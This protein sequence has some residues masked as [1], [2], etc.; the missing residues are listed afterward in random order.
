[1]KKLQIGID[2]GTTNSVVAYLENGSIEYLR[3]KNRET[4]AST[5]LYQIGKVTVGDMA[6]RKSAIYPQNF[7]KSS[8][9]FMGDITKEWII[10][11]KSFSPTDVA[12]EILLEMY[13]GLRKQFKSL[14]EIEAVITVPAYFTSSQIDETKKA[15]ERAG[16]IIKQIITEPVSAAIAYGFEENT[17]QRLFIVDIGGG[18]FDTAILEVNNRNFETKAIDGDNHLGGDDFD[19]IILELLL[20]Y[21]RKNEGVNLSALK[22]SGLEEKEYRQ[23]YQAL[24]NKAEE[25]KIALSEY[26][27][28]EVEIPN[29]FGS[30]NL[31][32][33]ITREEFE[34]ASSIIIE[35]IKRTIKNTLDDNGFTAQDID[36]VV[37]VGG[38]S[39]I[40]IINKFVTELFKEKPYADKPLDKLVAIG[41]SILAKDS[42]GIQDKIVIQDIL[43]HSLG[44]ELINEV[45][46]PLLKKNDKYPIK[47]SEVYTTVMDY[48]S[49][50]DINVYEGE[51]NSVNNN[52]FYGGFTLNN[53]E[54]AQA[55]TPQIEVTFEFDSNR[56]LNVTAKDLN[57]N[58]SKSETIEI[59]KGSKKKIT[60]KQKPYDIVL[61]IDVSW[62]MRG[63]P[64]DK[65]KIACSKLV[66]EMI[67][68][69]L[70]S[71]GIVAFG[72]TAK[73][74][75]DLS[76]NKSNLNSSINSLYCNG[77]TNMSAGLKVS[78]KKVLDT[79]T[80]TQLIILVTDG[81]PDDSY[82]VE[83]QASKLKENS[84]ELVT[85]GIGS[86][87]DRM[88]LTNIASSPSNYY[89]GNNFDDLSNI[90]QKISS[91]LRQK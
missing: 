29:L 19:K 45:F 32:T 2:L 9:A 18:T 87:I 20:K 33:I 6:K 56:I 49:E 37:L 12:T 15:G 65:A 41:A 10:E 21:I 83:V 46:S 23:A 76:N 53:I 59:D 91:S 34:K 42:E 89:E 80:N 69:T 1:M 78:R 79:S 11:D 62:S 7:I 67:D 82:N 63:T 72:S 4:L 68:L 8:K 52:D 70:H 77:S 44:I 47:H 84:I 22:K 24:V 57:T 90:F 66:S 27:E 38:S 60:P 40:P 30:Y 26:D 35:K 39:K 54:Q 81:Y 85:I 25:T 50:L 43:S 88:L 73:K 51:D 86:G 28:Y 64:L 61:L 31:T 75:L 55:G 17:N 5:I 58:S 71:V 16:F 36:K 3:F 14:E 48:Q 13:K 74:Y